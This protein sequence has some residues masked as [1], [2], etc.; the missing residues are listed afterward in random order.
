MRGARMTWPIRRLANCLAALSLLAPLPGQAIEPVVVQADL[1]LGSAAGLWSEGATVQALGRWGRLVAGLRGT[2][3]WE[4]PA[5][6]WLP[7]LL[8]PQ[9]GPQRTAAVEI[10]PRVGVLLAYHQTPASQTSQHSERIGRRCLDP[11]C[12]RVEEQWLVRRRVLLGD[13]TQAWTLIGGL[14]LR[15]QDGVGLASRLGLRWQAS[16][17]NHEAPWTN[18][19][20]EAGLQHASTLARGWS[21]DGSDGLGIGGWLEAGAT[22]GG[23]KS[24]GARLEVGGMRRPDGRADVVGV[25]Y[26]GYARPGR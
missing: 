14:R 23:W 2:V 17:P 3:R 1:A 24:V 25:L 18:R 21:R 15:S 26:F 13:E 9:A 7:W 19:W 20:M 16:G 12:N 6:A 10:E 5:E 11:D 8:W 22:V 4:A